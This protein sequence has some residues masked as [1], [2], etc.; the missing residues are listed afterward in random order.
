MVEHFIFFLSSGIS[1]DLGFDSGDD[2][3]EI[4][5]D[6]DAWGNTCLDGEHTI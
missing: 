1:E 6:V 3:S 4:S 2:L 5:G